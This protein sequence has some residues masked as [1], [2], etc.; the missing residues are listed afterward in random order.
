MTIFRKFAAVIE[1]SPEP[2]L[3]SV[4]VWPLAI[5]YSLAGWVIFS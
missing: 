3:F 2:V 5:A 4:F 1:A